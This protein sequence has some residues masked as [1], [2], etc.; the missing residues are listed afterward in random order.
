MGKA[1]A[2][3]IEWTGD[4]K[5]DC[6]ARLGTLVA[7]CECMGDL[8]CRDIDHP[9]DKPWPMETW[10]ASVSDRGETIFHSS[11]VGGTF[12]TGELARAVCEAIMLA[13]HR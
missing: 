10:Y 7:H 5:D 9:R 12:T 4:L 3:K 1:V 2:E 13:R 11:E 8:L 6:V